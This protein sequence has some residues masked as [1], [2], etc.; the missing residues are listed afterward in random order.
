MNR[1][2]AV[3]YGNVI[4]E[5]LLLVIGVVALVFLGLLTITAIVMP[6]D[7]ETGILLSVLI[8]MDALCMMLI[9]WSR[10][11]HK[12][13][14]TYKQYIV[15]L[16]N[17]PTGSISNLAEATCTAQDVVIKNLELLI[18]KKFL[19]NAYIDRGLNRIILPRDGASCEG[20]PDS[21]N[22][23]EMVTVI[24]DGCGGVNTVVQ[25]QTAECEYCGS[26]IQG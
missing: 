8:P 12:L 18:Y 25:G 20:E 21:R 9:V 24:C 4:A 2:K 15:L 16:S 14:Q 19:Q 6:S 23:G 3:Y 26:P 1:S 7:P 17:D 13:I 10:K 11:K 5:K 22:G